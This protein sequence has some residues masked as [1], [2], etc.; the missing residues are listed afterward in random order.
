[1]HFLRKKAIEKNILYE[2]RFIL[3]TGMGDKDGYI[4]LGCCRNFCNRLVY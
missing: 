1:M 4:I 2:S 3:I